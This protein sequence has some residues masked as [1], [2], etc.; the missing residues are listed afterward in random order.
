MRKKEKEIKDSRTAKLQRLERFIKIYS[1]KIVHQV[2][3]S[4]TIEKR[5]K[6]A[7]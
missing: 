5:H 4:G 2:Y 7:Y 6:K 3:I 1:R